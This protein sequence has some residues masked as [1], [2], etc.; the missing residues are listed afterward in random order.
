MTLKNK[1]I[2]ENYYNLKIDFNTIGNIMSSGER[3]S[4]FSSKWSRGREIDGTFQI[5]NIEKTP[6][7]VDLYK[8]LEN[9]FNPVKAFKTNLDI[10]FSFRPGATSNIHKD[11][12]QVYILAV[13]GMTAYRI[14]NN[15]FFIKPGNLINIKPGEIHQAISLDPRIV[16]SYETRRDHEKE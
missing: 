2:T 10:F 4:Y 15:K 5:K 1:R 16:V 13:M 11:T 3:E 9:D 14:N 12:Y 7:F 8:K 6:L